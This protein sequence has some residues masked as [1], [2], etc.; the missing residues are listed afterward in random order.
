MGIIE[1]ALHRFCCLLIELKD[2]H[3]A[4]TQEFIQ[5]RLDLVFGVY[6]CKTSP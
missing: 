4:T 6:G 1:V 2:E 5:I 3:Y